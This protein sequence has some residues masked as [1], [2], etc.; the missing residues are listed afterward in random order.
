MLR[1]KLISDSTLRRLINA[2]NEVEARKNAGRRP[3]QGL[4]NERIVALQE[5]MQSLDKKDANEVLVFELA[6]PELRAERYAK[7]QPGRSNLDPD[8]QVQRMTGAYYFHLINYV[9]HELVVEK[10]LR[11]LD[12]LSL[13]EHPQ[14]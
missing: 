10:G 14:A 12:D 6:D 7:L 9:K 2:A 1:K 8:I 5:A 11:T 4:S 13:P 3:F